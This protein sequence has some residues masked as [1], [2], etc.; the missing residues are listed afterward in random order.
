M[1]IK[2]NKKKAVKRVNFKSSH[3]KEKNCTC[4]KYGH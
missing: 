3:P 1:P 4:K 2:L